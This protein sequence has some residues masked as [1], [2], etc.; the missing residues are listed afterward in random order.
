MEVEDALAAGT[1]AGFD[2]RFFDVHVEGVK[3]HAE[4]VR[5]DTLDARIDD[6]RQA[7]G[8][9]EHVRAQFHGYGGALRLRLVDDDFEALARLFLILICAKSGP[10]AIQRLITIL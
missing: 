2:I 4:V 7:G 10:E 1:H 9:H 8:F 5:A 6:L 3:Q